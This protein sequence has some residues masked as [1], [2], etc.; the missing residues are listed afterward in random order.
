MDALTCLKTRRSVRA[1]EKRPVAREILTDIVDCARLA[2]SA[3]NGQ[4]WEFVVVTRPDT[5]RKLGALIQHAKFVP[6]LPAAVA[7]FVKTHTF[8]AEDGSA[9]TLNMLLAAKAHGLGSVW[10][11]GDKQPY[12]DAVRQLLGAPADYRFFS[13]VALGYPAEDPAPEKRDIKA[14]IHWEKY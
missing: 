1:Y 5:F 2:P 12:A 10:V 14:M 11:S 8:C 7:V 9:A 4:P 3:M 13:L 6:D